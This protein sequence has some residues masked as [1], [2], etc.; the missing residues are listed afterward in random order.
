MIDSPA[1]PV[2]AIRRD[3]TS[4]PREAATARATTG[5]APVAGAYHVREVVEQAITPNDYPRLISLVRALAP[6]AGSA[7]ELGDGLQW[8]HDSGFTS[9]SLTINPE[10]TG[11]VIRADLRTD[12]EQVAY[13]LGA[14]GAALLAAIT[15]TGAHFP[16]GGIIGSGIATLVAGGWCARRLW[17][18]S[19][20]RQ[21]EELHRLVRA[22]AA[23]LRGELE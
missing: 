9:L 2:P 14:A 6:E 7:R 21:S 15:A 8:E 22:I 3:A 4:P 1:D 13:G 11:T 10:P 16:L 19:S 17:R 12:G 23:G 5:I 18:R 20:R